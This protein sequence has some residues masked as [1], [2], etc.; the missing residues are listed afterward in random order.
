MSSRFFH[1]FVSPHS[2]LF[3]SLEGL[4]MCL[5]ITWGKE[6][7]SSRSCSDCSL[8]NPIPSPRLLL[9]PVPVLLYLFLFLLSFPLI[10]HT[11]ASQKQLLLTIPSSRHS[12][13]DLFICSVPCVHI[14]WKCFRYGVVLGALMV[15][16]V[17]SANHHLSLST[18][19]SWESSGPGFDVL[20]PIAYFR[21][22]EIADGG[23]SLACS[24]FLI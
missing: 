8:T 24:T 12:E 3:S 21:F 4:F 16:S 11:C 19:I 6:S 14:A 15:L 5:R 17:V 9:L 10:S 2:G 20:N 22:S 13:Y 23:S 1:A 7:L 18:S